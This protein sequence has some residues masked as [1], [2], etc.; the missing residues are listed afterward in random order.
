MKNGYIKP[1]RNSIVQIPIEL[2]YRSRTIMRSGS[3][4]R[5][6]LRRYMNADEPILFI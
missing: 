3:Y 1:A 4:Y 6:M 2:S 5:D